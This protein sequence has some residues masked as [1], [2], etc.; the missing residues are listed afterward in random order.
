MPN[1]PAT[2]PRDNRKLSRM[3]NGVV[4]TFTYSNTGDATCPQQNFRLCTLV[5]TK[6]P[7][8]L[9]NLTYSYDNGGNV[10]GITNPLGGNESYG[11]DALDRLSSA[12][13]PYGSLTSTFDQIGNITSITSSTQGTV[14]YTYPSSGG[15]SVRPHAV[16]TV[17]S[18]SYSYDNNGNMTSGASRTLS[19][20]SRTGPRALAET[21]SRQR[22][23]TMGTAGGSR[24]SSAGRGRFISASSMSA[25]LCLREVHLAFYCCAGKG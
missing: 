18:N 10:L 3:A 11:Y 21:A 12:T 8:T 7:T 23:S 14:T 5:T 22:W 20:A 13:A 24:R 15:S 19:Y 2:M 4:T 9:Q 1:M 6:T 17:G 16:S 25:P